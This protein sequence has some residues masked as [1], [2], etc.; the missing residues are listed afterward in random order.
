MN[1][2][3]FYS[4]DQYDALVGYYESTYDKL[5]ALNPPVTMMFAPGKPET[6]PFALWQGFINGKQPEL[7]VYEDHP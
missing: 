2:P 3:I 4:E 6:N 1:E 5:S 7:L